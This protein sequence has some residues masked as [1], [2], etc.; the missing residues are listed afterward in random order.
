M[1]AP[2]ALSLADAIIH[3]PNF[4]RVELSR[5][6]FGNCGADPHVMHTVEAAA[7]QVSPAQ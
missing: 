4:R 1:D 2:A 5:L 7:Q 6:P 3:S